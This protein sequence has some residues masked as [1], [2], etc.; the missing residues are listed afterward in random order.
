VI[1]CLLSAKSKSILMGFLV[2]VLLA[3]CGHSN[4]I[5]TSNPVSFTPSP[6]VFSLKVPGS[7]AQAQSKVP[8]EV[9]AAFSDST[10]QAEL[11]A[12]AGLLDRRLTDEEGFKA[13]TG[14]ID[15]LLRHPADLTV[16]DQQRRADG[17]FVVKVA[18]TRNNEKQIGEA[19][20]F[21][22]NLALSGVISAGP[23][24][25]W[26]DLSNDLQ[27]FVKSF[28]IDPEIVQGAYFT[29][30]DNAG[31]SFVAP[32]DWQQQTNLAGSVVR[33]PTGQLTIMAMQRP[34]TTTL[35][36]QALQDLATRL[37]VAN[38]SPGKVTGTEM[39]PDGRLKI[40][41]DRPKHRVIGYVDQKD[42]VFAGLFFDAP[43]ERAEAYQP[44]IDFV[45]STFVT[46]KP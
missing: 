45:Y 3:A 40:V 44:F 20:V 10:H 23:E 26:P 18:F 12:Y 17:A 31:Y 6:Q 16:T 24:A 34:L 15:N 36:S 8:T 9:M 33:S 19:V 1:A 41:L 25:F 2:A 29:P 21:D 13:I 22:T 4:P 35:D 11:I 30:V 14:L 27:P 7:W 28:Q 43:S 32:A 38:G 37:M 42:Q 39:L 5:D 46:G